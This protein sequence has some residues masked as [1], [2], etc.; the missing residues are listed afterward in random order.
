MILECMLA[1]TVLA[2]GP[3]DEAELLKLERVWNEA[4]VRGDAEVLGGLWADD[5]VV[6]VPRMRTLSKAEALAVVRV[7]KVRFPRYE[8]SDIRV[9]VYGDAAVV[10][11][12][13][14]RTRQMGE[15]AV[16]DDWQFTK[17]YVRQADRWRVVAFHASDAHG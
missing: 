15:T 16:E 14:R 8:T 6:V 13:L 3:S 2:Q 9:R 17:V 4:H 10:T 5:L 7:A 11:G 1:A 12:R